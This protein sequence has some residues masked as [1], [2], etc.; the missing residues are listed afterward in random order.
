[1]AGVPALAA[2]SVN[3]D[4]WTLY[5]SRFLDVSGRIIDD[6]NG[7]ISHSEGQGYGLLLAVFA[8]AQADFDL[9]WSFTRTE[10]LLR[11]DGLAVWKWEPGASPHVTDP[12]NATDGDILIAYALGLAGDAWNRPDLLAAGQA[13]ASAIAQHTLKEDGGR[14][15]LMPAAAGF[16]RA[17]RPDGP[18]V[19]PSYWV[20]EAFP[21]LQRLWPEG[22]WERVESD[23]AALLPQARMGET[24]LPPDWLSVHTRPVPADGFP[25]E[26]AYNAIRV[27]LYLMRAGRT[28]RDLLAPM[29]E[30]MSNGQ[31]AVRTVKPDGA[32]GE[33]LADPGYRIIPALGAC[34]LD[35]TPIP[36]ELRTLSATAYYPSTLQLLALSF[37]RSRH[38]ECL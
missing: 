2:P 38:A 31:G 36:A 28:E 12:N 26:F 29:L 14:L 20:W 18:V 4:E 13:L 16:G 24:G 6:A 17:D 7:S 3:P 30:N 1:M 33:T 15:L 37:A 9:I 10:L 8:D 23:G 19:N 11:D 32:T 21:V 25:A 22:P 5:K 34:L 35:K 27:P